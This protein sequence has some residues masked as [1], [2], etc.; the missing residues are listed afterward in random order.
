MLST[1]FTIIVKFRT[2]AG[3]WS[4]W[5]EIRPQVAFGSDIPMGA[6]RR[7]LEGTEALPGEYLLRCDQDQVGSGTLMRTVNW[8]PPEL[9]FECP[10]CRGMGE[11]VGLFEV[12]TCKVCGGRKVVAG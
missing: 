10:S 3:Q 1:G 8:Q 2:Q 6:V 12:E 5:F 11:Y 9:L 7:L 4:A